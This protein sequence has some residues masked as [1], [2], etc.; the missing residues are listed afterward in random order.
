MT[1]EK[2]LG[3][4]MVASLF[5]EAV[6]VEVTAPDGDEA[7]GIL[8]AIERGDQL[9]WASVDVVCHLDIEGVQIHG[10]CPIVHPDSEGDPY[11]PFSVIA[12]LAG[13]DE[14]ADPL[15][16]FVTLYEAQL[17]VAEE[18]AR[19]LLMEKLQAVQTT[20]NE[21]FAEVV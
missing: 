12:G 3:D 19:A 7:S 20:L 11:R 14:D 21:L 8:A 13:V 18:Q 4:L 9:A 10:S 6:P 5:V 1:P 2:T 16:V 15:E 17:G